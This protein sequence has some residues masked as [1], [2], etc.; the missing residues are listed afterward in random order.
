[1][2]TNRNT[3]SSSLQLMREYFNNR[4]ARSHEFR[5]NRL[6]ELKRA[7][8]K[9]EKLLLK[10]LYEDLKKSTEESYATE[11]GLVVTE[12]NV[13]IKNLK[14]W[15]RPSSASTN[16]V[17]LPSASKIYHDPLGVVL[18]IAPW[19]YPL[20][21]SLIP[22]VG[23]IAGGNCAV[24][25]PSELAP[26]T[27]RVIEQIISEIY[28]REY[29]LVIQGDGAEIIPGLMSD[30]R[31][32]HIFYTGSISVGRSIYKLAAEQLIPVTLELGGKS[33]A[34]VHRDANIGVA[35]RRI[36]MGKFL[37]AGQTCIAPDYVLVHVD[38]SE[39]LISR[40]SDS[41][42][43]FYSDDPSGSE[44]YARIINEK[45]FDKLQSY[46]VE[47]TI[48]TG[49]K[50]DRENLYFSP[51]VLKD[52]PE[53]AS[54][55]TDEIFGPILPVLTFNT[56]EEAMAI[57]QRNANP[58]AFY[59]FTN[60]K[61][62]QKHWIESTAFG[63][64][65]INNADWQFANHY[66]PFGGVGSSG[67]GCYH[68]KYTFDTFTRKKPVMKTPNWFDPSIKYPPMKGRL[69]LFKWLFR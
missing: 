31:F 14:K 45:R 39:K 64:G 34:I 13:A 30:F 41:L 25:K 44:D 37:N 47:G 4:N 59:V 21:L 62:I 8:T 60:D 11:I 51:T 27:A 10:A 50:T 35:A 15:M 32:D 61:A 66:L 58:L 55:M 52:V 36:V 67:M 20:Q 46:L 48:V 68:G 23:A 6:K 17:N 2:H 19:N 38:V 63:G 54:V 56:I 7:I 69:R 49:G 65:C 33:P 42:R 16:L 43:N 28:P 3:V 29:V 40:L 26:A 22:L 1:M 5:L 9:Y 12:I 18:I 24:V 57:V 53:N